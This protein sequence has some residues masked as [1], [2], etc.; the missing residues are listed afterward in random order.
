MLCLDGKTLKRENQTKEVYV[1]PGYSEKNNLTFKGE[2]NQQYRRDPT[3][4]IVSFVE[5]EADRS[6]PNY[7]LTK[8]YQRLGDD[9][10]YT[11]T[12]SL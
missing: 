1:R 3:D 4:L 2:G 11:H 7:E 10:V 8:K 5:V 12:L 9:L 6:N